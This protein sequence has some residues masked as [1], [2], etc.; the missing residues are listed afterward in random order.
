MILACRRKM[1]LHFA[2]LLAK[3]KLIRSKIYNYIEE[4]GGWVRVRV[5]VRVKGIGLGLG[6]GLHRG[7]RF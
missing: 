7:P 1:H 4:V 3:I 6:L 5:R 2:F